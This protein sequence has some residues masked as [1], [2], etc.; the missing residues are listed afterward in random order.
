MPIPFLRLESRLSKCQ[1]L[2]LD[3]IKTKRIEGITVIETGIETI[4]SKFIGILR[5][6]LTCVERAWEG[7]RARGV[8][9][10]EGLRLYLM[11]TG[12]E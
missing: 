8:I 10:S 7:V 12:H 6:S 2:F 11:N 9:E 4:N 5:S 1:S 3:W